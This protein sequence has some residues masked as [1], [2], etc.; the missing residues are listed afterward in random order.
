MKGLPCVVAI[1]MKDEARHIGACL[2]ALATQMTLNGLPIASGSFGVVLFA[3]NCRDESPRLARL[4]AD[5]LPYPLR[6]VEQRMP[7]SRAHAGGARR[8][9][10]DHAAR[11]LAEEDFKEAAILTTDADSRVAPSWIAANLSALALGVDAVLGRIALDEESAALPSALHDRGR[12]ESAYEQ[13]LCEISARLDPLEHNPWPHH[14]TISGASIGVNHRMYRKIGGMPCVPLGEDKAFIAALLCHDARLRYSP[15]VEVITS[16]RTSGRAP[17]GVA[18]T[19]RIRAQD[20]N[21]YCDESLEPCRT[22][23]KRAR[24]RAQ[25]REIWGNGFVRRSGGPLHVS[26]IERVFDR[27]ATF[28]AAWSAIESKNIALRR[29]LLKPDDLPGQIAEATRALS[30]LVQ[31]VSPRAEDVKSEVTASIL[32]N[33]AGGAFQIGDEQVGRLVAG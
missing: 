5:G 32:M 22:A 26:E 30:H 17:G 7:A 25:L 27:S 4:A 28:G 12:L 33:N 15:D 13:L 1:P 23:I 24:L 18:D 2:A 21:S 16:G 20:P 10:M 14:S 11:W 31:A 29:R 19:L 9:A 8:A 3:N 6:V